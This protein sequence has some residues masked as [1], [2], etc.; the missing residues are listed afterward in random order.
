LGNA[1]RGD[2]M[3]YDING[4]YIS[5]TTTKV[6]IASQGGGAQT[7]FTAGVLRKI[8]EYK[9]ELKEKKGIEIVGFSGTSGGAICS[10][11]VWYGLLKDNAIG[12]SGSPTAIKW[13]KDFWDYNSVKNF[14]GPKEIIEANQ[15]FSWFTNSIFFNQMVV[16]GGRK[17]HELGIFVEF[18]PYLYP[19]YVKK[20]LIKLLAPYKNFQNVQKWKNAINEKNKRKKDKD[21]I[22]IPF[23][24]MGAANV[25]TG[26]FGVFNSDFIDIND[27]ILLASGAIPTMVKAVE[28]NDNIYWDGLYS[29]NPPLRDLLG[30]HEESIFEKKYYKDFENVKKDFHE[31]KPDE[32]WI[33]R[34]NPKECY[35]E[36]KTLLRI[37]DRQNE[38]SGN[39]SLEQEIYFIKKINDLLPHLT[40][41]KYNYI[42]ME[43]N[44]VPLEIEINEEKLGMSLDLESKLNR[45]P[46][47]I[48]DLREHGEEQADEFII[49]VLNR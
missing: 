14:P 43:H 37:K 47:F 18:N 38:L 21:K 4:R 34:I 20:G 36:P 13:L 44:K 29:Q 9:P 12:N 39:L 15:W 41:N 28:I 25:K 3:V 7:A 19:E 30:F 16:Q 31:K 6:A 11:L 23:L 46:D 26:K 40:N 48:N 10:A 49:N 24:I 8:L 35:S 32:I 22:T 33:I 27:N 42:K 1:L 17:S 45:D 5:G 2:L